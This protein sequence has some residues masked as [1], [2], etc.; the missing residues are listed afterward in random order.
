MSP[1]RVH[2]QGLSRLSFSFLI[3]SGKAN[4]KALTDEIPD[5][6]VSPSVSLSTSPC[7]AVLET[8][9]FHA[10]DQSTLVAYPGN[11]KQYKYTLALS[12]EAQS[13]KLVTLGE[14][15]GQKNQATP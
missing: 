8:P 3:K 11:L 7:Q 15:W 1:T 2:A 9:P 14:N 5:S 13:P 12:S 6:R 4:G 10:S